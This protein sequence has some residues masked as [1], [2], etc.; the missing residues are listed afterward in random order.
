MK[1]GAGLMP[2]V[3]AHIGSYEFDHSIE[4]INGIDE[5]DG[6]SS[7][8]VTEIVDLPAGDSQHISWSFD[9]SPETGNSLTVKS[10]RARKSQFD[11]LDATSVTIYLSYHPI[12]EMVVVAS[13]NYMAPVYE[14]QSFASNSSE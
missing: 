7:L 12:G 14:V 6:D 1:R 10:F 2:T 13:D 5:A 11:Q 9:F 4:A 8:M 3:N